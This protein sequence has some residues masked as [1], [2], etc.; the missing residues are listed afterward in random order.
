MEL[1]PVSKGSYLLEILGELGYAKN[2]FNGAVPIDFTDIKAYTELAGVILTPWEALTLRNLS[3]AYAIENANKDPLAY[4]PSH[5]ELT[6][7]GASE[8]LAKFA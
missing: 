6:P 3:I 7:I 8:L 2:G 5:S 1:P 4:P